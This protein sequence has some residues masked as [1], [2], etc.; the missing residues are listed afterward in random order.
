[1]RRE[2]LE[3]EVDKPLESTFFLC[4][5]PPFMQ[6]AKA[7]L[8]EMEVDPASILQESFGAA[9][10]ANLPPVI[11]DAYQ[12]SF[13]R[14]QST[15]KISPSENLLESAEKNGV[16]LPSGCRQGVCGTCATRLLAGDVQ[17]R[18]HQALDEEQRSQGYILP[19]VSRVNSNVT[20]DA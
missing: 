2:I 14:S 5:P 6:H 4:G 11:A 10:A 17:M 1:L 7:L 9:I 13:A 16:L 12:V 3:R 8:A 20:L 19:C 15:F 18:S